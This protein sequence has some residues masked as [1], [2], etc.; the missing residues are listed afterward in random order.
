[1]QS[2]NYQEIDYTFLPYEDDEL[3]E[4]PYQNRY[5]NQ[6]EAV[7]EIIKQL[8][9]NPEEIDENQLHGDLMFLCIQ[10]GISIREYDNVELLSI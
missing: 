5:T 7:K 4:K 3:I 6:R 2:Y 8:I 1:M 9:N 10:N